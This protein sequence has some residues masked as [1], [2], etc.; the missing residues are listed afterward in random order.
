VN[1]DSIDNIKRQVVALIPTVL[2][3]GIGIA[4]ATLSTVT[5]YPIQ[6]R[7][8]IQSLYVSFADRKLPYFVRCIVLAN[9][10]LLQRKSAFCFLSYNAF[11]HINPDATLTRNAANSP[12]TT[13]LPL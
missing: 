5:I 8:V 2:Q 6:L 3:Y 10:R 9:V 11:L 7:Q 12:R 13:R 4:I 1:N